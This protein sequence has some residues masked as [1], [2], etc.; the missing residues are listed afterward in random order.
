LE[1]GREFTADTIKIEKDWVFYK[2]MPLRGISK[3]DQ[4]IRD[5]L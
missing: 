5:A 4:A 3:S 1:F 2:F